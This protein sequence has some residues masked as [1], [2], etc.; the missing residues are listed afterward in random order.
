MS[1]EISLSV[2]TKM[3]TIQINYN[4]SASAGSGVAEF[5]DAFR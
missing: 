3:D 4:F 1:L 5:H 2:L